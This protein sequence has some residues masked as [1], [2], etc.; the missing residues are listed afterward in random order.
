MSVNYWKIVSFYEE[1]ITRTGA[2]LEGKP[3]NYDCFQFEKKNN[4]KFY[5]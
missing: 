3:R 2:P 5:S 1:F 4:N